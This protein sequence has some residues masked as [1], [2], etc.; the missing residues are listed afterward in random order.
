MLRSR[1]AAY[2]SALPDFGLAAVAVLT[3][4]DP[5]ILGTEYVGRLFTLMLLEF[6]V[7]HSAAWMGTVA[8]ADQARGQRA[9]KVLGL[10][11]FYS[12]FAGGFA[13]A[14]KAWWPLISFW[15]LTANRLLAILTGATAEGHERAQIQHGW[16]ASALLYLVGIPVTLFLPLPALGIEPGMAGA[17]VEGSSGAW[18]DAPHRV[19]V[20]AA[21]YFFGM[22]VY[23]ARSWRPKKPFAQDPW[24][25]LVNPVD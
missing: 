12:L 18:V 21:F 2:A 7:M 13:L 6:I 14:A 25:G 9:L 24:K 11:A 3:W 17:I 20:F 16:A 1:L 22:G 19:I 23:T 10:G 15:G 8:F 4:M 5:T